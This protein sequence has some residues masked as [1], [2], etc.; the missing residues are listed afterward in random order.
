MKRRKKATLDDF[1]SST[2]LVNEIAGLGAEMAS[3]W[4]MGDPQGK[5]KLRRFWN[6]RMGLKRAKPEPSWGDRVDVDL[7]GSRG[8]IYV[9]ESGVVLD[10]GKR[11]LRGSYGYWL[12]YLED[13]KLL[14]ERELA[15]MRAN[16]PV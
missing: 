12:L 10:Y 7:L 6:W 8:Y 4:T 11:P 1:I 9:R 16:Q 14:M 5:Y 15:A 13:V 2:R 3:N